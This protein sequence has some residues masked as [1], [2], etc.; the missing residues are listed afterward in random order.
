MFR[1]VLIVCLTLQSCMPTPNSTQ[2]L[3]WQQVWWYH[4]N[5]GADVKQDK[6]RIDPKNSLGKRKSHKVGIKQ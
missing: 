1:F 2:S 5:D 3:Q 4:D 6:P